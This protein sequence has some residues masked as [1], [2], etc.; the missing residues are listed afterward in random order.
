M[1]K[2]AKICIV[3]MWIA[4]FQTGLF[5][6]GN[7]GQSGANF[8]Q[9]PVEPRG[10]ALG[11]AMSA[12]A[13]GGAALYWN[14]AGAVASS[15]LDMVFSYTDWLLDTRVTY[16][17]ITKTMG[18]V[19]AIGI[20][21]TSLYMDEMEITTPYASEGT[22]QY[23]DAGDLA[24]GLTF[25]RQMVDFFKFGA[26]VKYIY[27]YIWNESA[28][29]V[30]FDIGGIYSAKHFY[31]F[32]IGM[33]ILNIS[34]KM[35]LSGDDINARIDEELQSGEDPATNPRVERLTPEYRLPQTLYLSVAADPVKTEQTVITLISGVEVPADNEQRM[36][37][38]FEA[39]VMKQFFLRG[40]YRFNHDLMDF[41]AGAGFKLKL[42]GVNSIVDY[43]YSSMDVFGGI[44]QFALRLTI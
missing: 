37:I 7:L 33:S 38:G 4:L 15:N 10:S 12:L 34:G 29:L 30:A 3:V 8:L 20:S 23:Y 2:M 19:N 17:G 43:S 44:H 5:S 35:K 24:I 9:I 25:A 22:G 11:G 1:K 28:G 41:S 39:A 18:G 42:M 13:Q 32:K 36:T 27:E 21:V 14:P 16:A 40:G 31:N 6:Q 26:T